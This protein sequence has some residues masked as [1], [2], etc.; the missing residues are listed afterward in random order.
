MQFMKM[1]VSFF[2]GQTLRSILD[3]KVG[4]LLSEFLIEF[5]L[6]LWCQILLS[7]VTNKLSESWRRMHVQCGSNPSSDSR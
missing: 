1:C 7:K 5:A 6:E 4:H 3:N 2:M